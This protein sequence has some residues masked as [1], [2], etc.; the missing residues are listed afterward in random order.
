MPSGTGNEAAGKSGMMQNNL[1][2][3]LPMSGSMTGPV[4]L[5]LNEGAGIKQGG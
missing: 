2:G 3:R 4:G 5:P 1:L